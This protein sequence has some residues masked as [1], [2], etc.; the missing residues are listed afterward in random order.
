MESAEK[1]GLESLLDSWGFSYIL[2]TLKGRFIK[3]NFCKLTKMLVKRRHAT[4]PLFG[5]GCVVAF[6][7]HI[8][9]VKIITCIDFCL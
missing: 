1:D 6:I 5:F 7:V 4:I 9:S 8:K 2:Q 3:N